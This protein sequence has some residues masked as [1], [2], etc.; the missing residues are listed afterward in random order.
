MPAYGSEPESQGGRR[1]GV[2]AVTFLILALATSYLP[3]PAQQR[4]AWSLRVTLLR[5]F[6][7]TQE[8]LTEALQALATDPFFKAVLDRA[9][10]RVDEAFTTSGNK[11]KGKTFRSWLAYR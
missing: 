10:G 8:R 7:A 4:V 9:Q 6:L 3:A 1:Q 2:L 5:P 11:R